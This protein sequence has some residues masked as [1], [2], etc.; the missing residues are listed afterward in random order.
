MKLKFG[1]SLQT[2]VKVDTL[3]SDD[4]EVTKVQCGENVKVKLKGVDESDIS[5]GFV[6]CD[7]NNP[8]K[9]T[10]VFDAQVRKT[11]N[12]LILTSEGPL[13]SCSRL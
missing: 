9:S 10:K 3:W 1:H 11:S 6:L 12:N 5:T 7:K 8:I 4:I 13:T 2:E